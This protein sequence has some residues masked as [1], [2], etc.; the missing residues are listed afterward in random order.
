MFARKFF[1]FSLLFFLFSL[2]GAIANKK[3]KKE[4]NSH[5]TP[6]T[7]T[8]HCGRPSDLFGLE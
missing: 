6:I 1:F 2:I 4:K 5:F 7:S 8:T 3:K